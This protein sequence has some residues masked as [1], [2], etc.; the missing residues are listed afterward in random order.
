MLVEHRSRST[1]GVPGDAVARYDRRVKLVALVMAAVIA[2]GCHHANGPTVTGA[3]LY[4]QVAALQA[5]KHAPVVTGAGTLDVRTEQYLIAGEQLFVV[6]QIVDKCKGGD[7]TADPDC[8]LA[9]LIDKT[10]RLRDQPPVPREPGGGG[11]D[12]SVR[13]KALLVLTAIGAGMT[14]G[15]FKCE[16]FDGCKGL[17]GIGAGLDGLLILI[18][19]GSGRD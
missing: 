15:A 11:H 1:D 3:A 7:P 9:L 5:D 18:I 6:G 8:T 12:L 16:L 17:L 2:G 4:A 14:Y 10:F 13:T 19:L